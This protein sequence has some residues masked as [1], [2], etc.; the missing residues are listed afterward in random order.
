MASLGKR[1]YEYRRLLN[2]D[3]ETLLRK[4]VKK[5]KAW[6]KF[7]A[8]ASRRRPRIRVAGLR[9]FIRKRTK[10]LSKF[11]IHW[12]K[13]MKRLKNGQ[14]HM[15]DLFGANYLFMQPNSTPFGCRQ[16]QPRNNYKGYGHHHHHQGFSTTFS[17]GRIA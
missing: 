2:E 7:R 4:Q 11:K 15:N 13:A 17:V 6:L 3:E 5:A 1:S 12:R 10:V 14:S 8:L 9:K 16:K